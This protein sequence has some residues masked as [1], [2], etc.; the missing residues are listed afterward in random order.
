MDV[1]CSQQSETE[2]RADHTLAYHTK[3]RSVEANVAARTLEATKPRL[4][5]ISIRSH[6]NPVPC[7]DSA[8]CIDGLD[9]LCRE[10]VG[11]FELLDR[12]AM[13]YPL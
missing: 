13:E 11:G 8:K 1:A 3:P 6:T 10:D 12:V 4:V 7:G 2:V 9:T 5:K